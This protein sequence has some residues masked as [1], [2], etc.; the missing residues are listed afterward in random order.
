MATARADKAMSALKRLKALLV[1]R[2]A[3]RIMPAAVGVSKAIFGTTILGLSDARLRSLRNEV[4]QA[5]V[6]HKGN[7]AALELITTLLLDATKSDP[8]VASDQGA[9]MV[10]KRLIERDKGVVETIDEVDL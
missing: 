1:P 10:V 4:I 8:K 6:G 2:R 3:R 7:H 9:I 5:V